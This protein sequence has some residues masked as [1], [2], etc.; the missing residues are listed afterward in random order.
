MTVTKILIADDDP[1][2]REA[3]KKI[4]EIFGYNVT[5]V[6]NGQQ[7]IDAVNES[8]S[9]IILDINMPVMDGTEATKILINITGIFMSIKFY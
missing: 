5:A 2:V 9:A 4:L 7:A 6:S 8:F 3:I 1:F